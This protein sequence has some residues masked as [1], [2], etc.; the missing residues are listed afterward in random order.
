MAMRVPTFIGLSFILEWKIHA[1]K[2]RSF[3]SRVM[4]W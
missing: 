3:G 2:M 4:D 1:S